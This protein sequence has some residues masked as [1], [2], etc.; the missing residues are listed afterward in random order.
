MFRIF[1]EHVVPPLDMAQYIVDNLVDL[2]D[3]VTKRDEQ[4][5]LKNAILFENLGNYETKV[6]RFRSLWETTD[7]P[8][9]KER[10]WE[11]LERF[12]T[13]GKMCTKIHGLTKRPVN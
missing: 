13:L 3:K 2:E 1:V 10:I 9:N 12:I 5:F 7:D 6:N 11:W 4:Y 8:D